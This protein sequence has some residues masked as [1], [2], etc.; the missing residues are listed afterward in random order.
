MK[1]S[2][3]S[4][5][6]QPNGHGSLIFAQNLRVLKSWKI[7]AQ[8]SFA[9]VAI[10]FSI[11]FFDQITKW[12]AVYGGLNYFCNSNGPFGISGHFSV[13]SAIVLGIIL[14]Y[15]RQEKDSDSKIALIFILAAGFSN[16]LDRLIFGCVRDFINLGFWPAF[17]FAD[18][19]ITIGAIYII[20]RKSK[21]YFR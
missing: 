19:I 12:V 16:F 9:A 14:A 4:R 3:K 11:I 21:E 2:V 10:F 8:N 15:S 13:I 20:Y 5:E 6:L 1:S 18:L 17:N 7:F